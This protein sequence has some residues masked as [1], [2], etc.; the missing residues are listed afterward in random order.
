MARRQVASDEQKTSGGPSG[1]S[2]G[3]AR[4]AAEEPTFEQSL[5]E[6]EEIVAQLEAGEKPLDESLVLYEKGVAALKRCHAILDTA[7][8][9]IRVLV[10]G[11]D[12]GVS[13]EEAQALQPPKGATAEHDTAAA[14]EAAEADTEARGARKRAG[15]RTVDGK[16]APR[17]N[18][19]PATASDERANGDSGGA[20]GSLFGGSR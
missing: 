7:E 3:A 12:G 2:A 20:G 4:Q 5:A 16:P 19:G 11:A 17:K 1:Q 18:A 9:R 10:K 13:L 6:L 14:G 8:Q 15:R